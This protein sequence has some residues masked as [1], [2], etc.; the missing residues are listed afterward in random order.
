MGLLSKIFSGI[1]K[2][3]KGVAKGIKNVVKGVAKVVKKVAKSKIFKAVLV[4]AAIYVT[5]G[6]AAGAFGS[7]GA[8]ATSVSNF[9]GSGTFLA[10]VATPFAKLGTALGTGARGVSD[11]VGFTEKGAKLGADAITGGSAVSEISGTMPSTM[12]P[13]AAQQAIT[14]GS[15]YYDPVNQIYIDKATG[16]AV[17]GEWWKQRAAD[18]AAEQGVGPTASAATKVTKGGRWAQGTILGDVARGVGTSV[19]S[20]YLMD[21]INPAFEE[22]RMAGLSL[23]GPGNKDPFAV[24]DSNGQPLSVSDAYSSLMYGNIDP[25]AAKDPLYTQATLPA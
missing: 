15:T 7:T 25:F 9:M 3:V 20:G 10:K 6:A 4:A 16:K 17:T 24:Y 23:E 2:I 5:G 19:A 11:F 13:T 18:I 22:G 12:A 21:K 1:K 8:W 14:A